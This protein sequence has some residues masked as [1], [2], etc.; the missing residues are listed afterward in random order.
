VWKSACQ[1][2]FLCR[3]KQLV[4]M[5]SMLSKW[6][7]NSRIKQSGV[8]AREQ[9]ESQDPS[10][11]SNDPNESITPRIVQVCQFDLSSSDICP[12]NETA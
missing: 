12:T 11:I 7:R 2:K 5:K 9:T 6:I 4:I 8:I 10:N 3:E 1:N